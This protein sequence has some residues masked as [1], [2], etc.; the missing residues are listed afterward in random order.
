[1]QNSAVC[2]CGKWNK[3]ICEKIETQAL[4]GREAL[5]VP[6]EWWG[7]GL[8]GVRARARRDRLGEQRTCHTDSTVDRSK[9]VY[10]EKDYVCVHGTP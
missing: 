7:R 8:C 9:W 10:G 5:A 2:Q 3:S 4:R 6:S 1:M